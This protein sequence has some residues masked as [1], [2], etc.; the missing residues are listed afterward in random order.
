MVCHLFCRLTIYVF[1]LF[2]S[3][4]LP[5]SI[6][7]NSAASAFSI[8]WHIPY[9]MRQFSLHVFVAPMNETKMKNMKQNTKKRIFYEKSQNTLK[10]KQEMRYMSL[11]TLCIGCQ[12]TNKKYILRFVWNW[13]FIKIVDAAT[14]NEN[15]TTVLYWNKFVGTGAQVIIL[16]LWRKLSVLCTEGAILNSLFFLRLLKI[17]FYFVWSKLFE[18]SFITQEWNKNRTQKEEKGNWTRC[19]NFSSTFIHIIIG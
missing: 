3:L 7:E 5:S 12:V 9:L 1:F 13:I 4:L 10:I 15:L 6:W 18:N 2:I 16:L 8:F 14:V 19:S 11:W 17:R